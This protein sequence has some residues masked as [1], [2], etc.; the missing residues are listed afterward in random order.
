MTFAYLDSITIAAHHAFDLDLPLNSG[1]TR[2]PTRRPCSPGSI[3]TARAAPGSTDTCPHP[4][5]S[6][7]RLRPD[8]PPT[9][10]PR[11]RHPRPCATP[12]PPPPPAPPLRC[13]ERYR[14][15]IEKRCLCAFSFYFNRQGRPWGAHFS[16]THLHDHACKHSLRTPGRHPARYLYRQPVWRSLSRSSWSRPSTVWLT[17]WRLP[18]TG[19]TG[20]SMASA[21]AALYMAPASDTIFDVSCENGFDGKLSATRLACHGLSL[22]IQPSVVW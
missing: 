2:S 18:T 16:G 8:W 6:P 20:T 12:G 9:R 15:S 14:A 10:A 1:P 13:P 3:A 22:R 7:A 4:A 19:A 11:P 5:P 17:G 21:M